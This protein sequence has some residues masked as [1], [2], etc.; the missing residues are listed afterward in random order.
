MALKLFGGRHQGKGYPTVDELLRFGREVC[1]VTQPAQ[2]LHRLAQG[3]S[4]ALAGALGD[5]RIP[6]TTRDAMAEYWQLG[7]GYAAG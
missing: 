1:G 4:H 6:P 3:M 7:M 5:A 2:V